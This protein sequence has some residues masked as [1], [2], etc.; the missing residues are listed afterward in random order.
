LFERAMRRSAKLGRTGGAAVMSRIGCA[1]ALVLGVAVS[2]VVAPPQPTTPERRAEVSSAS[3][4]SS[5][6]VVDRRRPRRERAAAVTLPVSSALPSLPLSPVAFE[7]FSGVRLSVPVSPGPSLGASALPASLALPSVVVAQT[8]AL[9]SFPRSSAAGR[10]RPSALVPMYASFAT[11]QALDYHSTTR[12]LSKGTA[13]EANP[14]VRP[15]VD[16]RTAFITL[17]AAATVA[18]VYQAERM[19]KDHPV[20]AI[21]FMAAANGAMGVIVARNYSIR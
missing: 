13:R 8:P 5:R 10:T 7:A 15:V 6:P 14:L 3:S 17:K 21:V 1:L 20:R 18:I 16:N 11:L 12:A 4:A 19:W 2:T 9:P